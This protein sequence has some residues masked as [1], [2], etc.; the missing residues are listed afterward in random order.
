M[1]SQHLHMRQPISK[2]DHLAEALQQRRLACSAVRQCACACIACPKTIS[3]AA[4][5]EVI[6]TASGTCRSIAPACSEAG[7]GTRANTS[8]YIWATV[9]GYYFCSTG[10]IPAGSSRRAATPLQP[11]RTKA[12]SIPCA[13]T[14]CSC[15]QARKTAE[16]GFCIESLSSCI[17][18]R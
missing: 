8:R 11:S 3:L 2:T 1:G 16:M 5:A 14:P 12:A 10:D 17:P 9:K 6:R 4:L 13:M 7:H 15:N 18:R